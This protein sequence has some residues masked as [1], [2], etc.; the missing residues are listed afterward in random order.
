[1]TTGHKS[2]IHNDPNIAIIRPAQVSNERPT[3]IAAIL[4]IAAGNLVDFACGNA[5]PVDSNK[6]SRH[7]I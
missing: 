2:A 5:S 1:M 3:L 6:R 4:K 7:G